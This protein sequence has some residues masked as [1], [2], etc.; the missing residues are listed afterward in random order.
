MQPHFSITPIALSLL[1]GACVCSLFFGIVYIMLNGSNESSNDIR[2]KKG[3]GETEAKKKLEVYAVYKHQ[4]MLSL[5]R[6]F[7]F[8]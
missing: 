6:N 4:K 5:T 8:L 1:L 3:E 2:A 7:M